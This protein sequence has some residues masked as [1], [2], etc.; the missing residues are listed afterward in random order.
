[1]TTHGEIVVAKLLPRNGP[2]RLVLEGLDVARRPVVEQHDAEHV[3]VGV[4]GL[5][6]RRRR[7]TDDEA[8]LE[9]DVERPVG[10][11]RGRPVAGTSPRAD[12]RCPLTTTVRA[13]P[14]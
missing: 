1:M 3:A 8:D 7:A 6:A 10:A 9:L 11:S 2:E 5:D 13:R 12:D 14:W 4:V